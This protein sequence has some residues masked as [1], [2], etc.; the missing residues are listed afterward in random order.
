VSHRVIGVEQQGHGG[1]PDIDRPLSYD[2][3]ADD[4]IALLRQIGVA[5]A[6]FVGWSD[7][8]RVALRIAI[9]QPSM[10]R[11]LALI[12]TSSEEHG[13]RDE[14]VD[15]LDKDGPETWPPMVRDI[16]TRTAVQ[17]GRFPIVAAKLTALWRGFRGFAARDLAGIRAP[18][19]VVIGDRDS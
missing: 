16:Y 2:R 5:R 7:G 6:D 17:P 1:T 8:G 3:M 19:L 10:V 4:T 11:S 14:V 13:E 12:R 15:R 9:V 18:T